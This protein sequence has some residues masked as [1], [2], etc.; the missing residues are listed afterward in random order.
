MTKDA[1]RRLAEAYAASVPD[2]VHVPTLVK[3]IKRH[4]AKTIE[5]VR[6]IAS[7]LK[8]PDDETS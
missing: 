4:G 2:D 7:S 6:E 8:R 5:E 1:A 3:L